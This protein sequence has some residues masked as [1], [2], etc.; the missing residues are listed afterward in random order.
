M[1]FGSQSWTGWAVPRVLPKSTDEND[2]DHI[3]SINA[4]TARHQIDPSLL[5]SKKIANTSGVVE[6]KVHSSSSE[7]GS[8]EQ[9]CIDAN[10]ET[11]TLEVFMYPSKDTDAKKN[12][13]API[14]FMLERKSDELIEQTLQRMVLS[15]NKQIFKLTKSNGKQKKQ[16]QE[17]KSTNKSCVSVYKM[18]PSGSFIPWDVNGK[19]NV[20]LWTEALSTTIKIQLELINGI[21]ATFHAD[22]CPPT[23]LT[24]K[25]FEDFTG[26]VFHDIPLVIEVESLF[27][28]A[29]VIDW[30]VGDE[31]VSNDNAAYTPQATHI[32]KHVSVIITPVR[33]NILSGRNYEQ[34]F[35]FKNPIEGLPLNTI[36]KLRQGD[37][38]T[39]CN[40]R[41]K[42]AT[43]K[44]LQSSP[45]RV[46]TYNILAD[47]NAYA[48]CNQGKQIPF[49]SY[50]SVSVLDRKRRMPLIIHEIL[51]YQSDIICLQEVDEHLWR[52]IF[53][54]V[55]E[56]AGYQG[57]WSGKDAFGM[58]EGCALFWSLHRFESISREEMKCFSLNQ[59][60]LDV[61]GEGDNTRWKSGAS[62]AT[63]LS[64]QPD[65]KDVI[66][67]KLGHVLQMV[68]LP[69]L[70]GENELES[71]SIPD[72]LLIANTHLFYH[73][74]GS[75]IRL[76]Q[77]YAICR[78]F[79]RFQSE[80]SSSYSMIMCGDMNSSLRRAAGYLLL[81]RQVLSCHTQLR[82]HFNTFEWIDRKNDCVDD[83][84]DTEHGEEGDDRSNDEWRDF[85]PIE[86]PDHFP[87]FLSGY[88]QEPKFTHY[89]D[90]FASALDHIFVS[91]SSEHN[92]FGL[93][94]IQCAPMPSVADV[95]EDVAMPSA[96]LP[97]D[98]VS[99]VSDLT[100]SRTC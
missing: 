3:L 76:M 42:Q 25:T 85:P 43:S 80:E 52:R 23:I 95:T 96:K 74:L 77:M 6:T 93:T 14:N 1:S 37:I 19:T 13:S 65:L 69:L 30:Y 72:R 64:E 75:H 55:L 49:Y 41:I 35:R 22:V 99:L 88:P 86:L 28:T 83:F 38:W 81:N 68:S 40:R 33:K 9:L 46:M 18:N 98:H 51:S 16:Q 56:N 66:E 24:V 63:V 84:N 44:K 57:F 73:P 45:L 31:L 20:Q 39:D 61:A 100:W 97:S 27:T 11:T 8:N 53:R 59:L 5:R 47:Q 70:R 32:G 71:K 89:L 29:V 17:E 91:Q 36:V 54:P 48:R 15:L 82:Q 21:T 2:H 10:S 94:P 4:M 90:S 60:V 58:A 79:E 67:N 78:Q 34:A 12:N 26:R 50:V 7:V 87:S 92:G 62:I